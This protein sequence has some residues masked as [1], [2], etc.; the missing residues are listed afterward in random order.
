VHQVDVDG[1]PV[2]K[3]YRLGVVSRLT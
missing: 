1:L 2:M 3:I